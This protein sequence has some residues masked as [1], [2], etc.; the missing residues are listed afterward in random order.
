MEIDGFDIIWG[1]SRINILAVTIAIFFIGLIIGILITSFAK[2]KIDRKSGGKVNKNT[3]YGLITLSILFGI[4]L[5]LVLLLGT[6]EF[7]YGW[8]ESEKYESYDV[9]FI[10]GKQEGIEDGRGEGYGEGYEEGYDVGVSAGK[11]SAGNYSYDNGYSVGYDDGYDAGYD[12][13]YDDGRAS[14]S[15]GSTSSSDS[16]SGSGS[17]SSVQTVTATVYITDTGS[18]YHRWGCQ[19]LRESSHAI[20]L[21]EARARGYTA[22]SR[23]W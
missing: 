16:S 14:I 23:C 2:E 7:I 20:L 5:I 22:C 1:S 12:E 21:T 3:K 13:G 6:K 15:S 10:A 17:S 19:Y 8:I 9:G 4:P 18:K 11:A